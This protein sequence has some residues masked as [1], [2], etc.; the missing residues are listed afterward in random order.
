L[1]ELVINL[2]SLKVRSHLLDARLEGRIILKWNETGR[3]DVNWINPDGDWVRQAFIL[4]TVLLISA[5]IALIR[6]TSKTVPGRCA[7]VL[8]SSEYVL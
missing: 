7:Y 4:V 1:A 5:W 3:E 6:A 2:D 8:M